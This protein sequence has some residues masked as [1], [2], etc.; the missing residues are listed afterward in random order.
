MRLSIIASLIAAATVATPARAASDIVPAWQ[1][2]DFVM[3]EVVV[4]ARAPVAPAWQA[5]DFVME[6]V[7]VTASA[8]G[9]PSAA[10]TR[11]VPLLAILAFRHARL[12]A[13]SEML[14]S[15]PG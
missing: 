4:T 7:V 14:R 12:R 2:P 6:E 8:G 13:L 1:S 5:Q 3:E 11:P 9:F 10:E 15:D